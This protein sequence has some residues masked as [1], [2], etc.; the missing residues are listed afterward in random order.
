MDSNK[1]YVVRSGPNLDRLRIIPPIESLKKGR[2]YLVGYVGVMG[3]QEGIDLLLRAARHVIK[4]M[5]RD[6]VHFG[7]VGGGTS[8]NEM[9]QM[10]IDL[11]INDYVT[12][13]GRIPDQDLLEMLN[14]A[15]VC[16][17][18][19]VA[20]EM[21]DKS[22]MNKI[23]EYMALAKPIVQFD[24]TEGRYSAQGSSLYAAEND[25]ED[26]ARK[27][28]DLLD[29]PIRR[30]LM[31]QYGRNR[32]ENELEWKYESPKLLAAYGALFQV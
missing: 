31:G 6:D 19:D 21:N 13:T 2:K 5:G 9:K 12:F 27:I 1:V 8:L 29:D 14:T 28:V 7:L 15:D 3:K 11:G 4:N 20:N 16:A 18:P 24:L 23:M 22:T 32:V 30:Q 10:A 26:M 25:P 17:N